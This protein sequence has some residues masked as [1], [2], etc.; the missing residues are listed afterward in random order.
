LTLKLSYCGHGEYALKRLALGFTQFERQLFST[1][2]KWSKRRQLQLQ[3]LDVAFGESTNVMID[4][5]DTNAMKWAGKRHWL[6]QKVVIWVDAPDTPRHS[7]ERRPV[8]W[9]W[10]PVLA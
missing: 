10:G 6:E 3:L 4:A 9:T 1:L 2:V 8:Q 7:V 5:A